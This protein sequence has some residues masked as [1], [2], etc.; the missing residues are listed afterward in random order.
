M[1][2]IR[3]TFAGLIAAAKV[4]REATTKCA[5]EENVQIGG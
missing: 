3:K 1:S 5:E 2:R 4:A